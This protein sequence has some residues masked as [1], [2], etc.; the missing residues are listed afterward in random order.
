MAVNNDLK[1]VKRTP[2]VG[3][4]WGY[5]QRSTSFAIIII[6][7]IITLIIGM[8][9][10]VAGL[11]PRGFVFWLLLAIIFLTSVSLNLLLT[12]GV[13]SFPLQKIWAAL[14]H[15]SGESP[16]GIVKPDINANKHLRPLLQKIYE[17]ST[18]EKD[19][20]KDDD[21]IKCS[22]KII[23]AA[24]A[25]DASSLVIL[26]EDR[27]ILYASKN[28]PISV[29]PKG[30]KKLD[31]IFEDKLDLSEWLSKETKNNIRAN[32]TWLRVPS[33]G[34]DDENRRLYDVSASYEKGS[35]A[36]VTLLL[37]DRTN[38]YQPEDDQLEFI[39]FAAHEL[40]GPITVIRG[41]LDVLEQE[42]EEGDPEVQLLLSRLVVSA[43][44][45]NSYIVNILNASRFDRRHMK[46]KISENH[47][48]DVYDSIAD[49]MELRA[50]TQERHL[51]VDI[52]KTLP[53]VAT[54]A[55]ALSEA[56]SNLIDN[57]IK[58]SF[59]GDTVTVNATTEG[60]FV[61]LDVIDTGIGMPPSV[62]RNLFH[63][64]Y[65]SHRSRDSV[66]GT[67]IGLYI[68]KGIAESIGGS[69]EVKST[70]GKG[71]TFSIFIPIY[72]T[73]ADRLN[74]AGDN[75]DLISDDTNFISNHA[76]FRG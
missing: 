23:D 28:A 66:S 5:Y 22:A 70:E 52:P 57:A 21:D 7:L 2:T 41:Y 56:L 64:F 44:R 45:L 58:Y 13:T 76:K 9:L 12:F 59:E 24:L 61:R 62:V 33:A 55:A 67:G 25:H 71:S 63:K 68:T 74:A 39:S 34:P 47:L 40:R 36:P 54:D 53:T 17:D 65:R 60:Q 31:L 4:F 29:K 42:F 30:G 10:V 8:A 38:F 43:N 18:T 73:V 20:K 15:V 75:A 48:Q 35:K 26:S 19:T 14:A 32:A 11:A 37:F 6:Q 49:D 46:I 51:I 1:K 16:Q 69:V 27:Q 72:A 50:S 3:S